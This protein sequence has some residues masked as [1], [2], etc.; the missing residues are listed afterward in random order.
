[1]A[2]QASS[3]DPDAR[4]EWVFAAINLGAVLLFAGFV[5]A[6]PDISAGE[7]L[8]LASLYLG[9]ALLILASA[10]ICFAG[11]VL[12]RGGR[13]SGW[14]AGPLGLVR[15]A[16]IGR[17]QDDR[18][19]SL[20]W[21][22]ALFALLLPSFNAFKQRILPDAGFV[23][24]AA[25]AS[26]DRAIF[27]VDPGLWL[28][29]AIGSPFATAFFDA[30]YHSWFVP[31]T[32]GIAVVGL[33][34]GVRTRA[35]YLTAYAGVWIVLGAL[36]AY[37]L[38]AAGPAFYTVLVDPG[39]AEPFTRVTEQLAA[40]GSGGGV[41]TSTHNQAYLLANLDSPAL[42]VG[43]GISAIPSVHNAIAVLFALASF[44][45]HWLCGVAMSLFAL[46]IWVGSVYLNW[47]Y[48]VDGLLGAAG[49]IGLWYGSAR[50]VDRIIAART[51]GTRPVRLAPAVSG[52]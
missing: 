44:R 14:R 6:D 46:L 28:H 20:L 19:A 3:R 27:G 30:I 47:H 23:H 10:L 45:A 33:T 36:F 1:M 48:A 22:L 37:L 40:T 35:Q 9:T 42:V 31:T 7:F 39:G 5:L 51:A 49:A 52:S 8:R 18:L 26:I 4:H 12:V 24:D 13:A 21:P 34:A 43:G 38:P 11:V 25:L 2:A 29:Q 15:A 17:W 41:L 32:L 16:L 50:L